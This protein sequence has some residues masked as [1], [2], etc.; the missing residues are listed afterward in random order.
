MSLKEIISHDNDSPITN[1]SQ[2]SQCMGKTRR[3]PI[4]EFYPWKSSHPTRT[5]NIHLK[6][7]F[8]RMNQHCLT[9]DV[10]L[11]LRRRENRVVFRPVEFELAV[12]DLYGITSNFRDN[13]GCKRTLDGTAHL[14][15]DAYRDTDC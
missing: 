3:I 12:G 15:D 14:I 7:L 8:A 6:L 13:G 5:E 1:T 2:A 4:S 10:S 11:L 9:D